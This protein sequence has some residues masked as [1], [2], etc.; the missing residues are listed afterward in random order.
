M[1][2]QEHIH[3]SSRSLPRTGAWSDERVL[4]D[5][6]CKR[7]GILYFAGE[8]ARIIG[9]EAL[10][11]SNARV[12]IWLRR[13]FSIGSLI[14]RS[15]LHTARPSRPEQKLLVKLYQGEPEIFRHPAVAVLLGLGDPLLVGG[16]RL[17]FA[18]EIGEY[19]AEA[20]I[21]VTF[22]VAVDS[23]IAPQNSR[24]IFATS[25]LL[26][27]VRQGQQ[28][29]RVVGVVGQHPLEIIY[30]VVHKNPPV[31]RC[32]CQYI[33]TSA[34]QHFST[35]ACWGAACVRFALCGGYGCASF[36]TE[37]GREFRGIT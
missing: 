3:A 10:R 2:H 4:P 33:S 28:P 6:L 23:D 32:M 13:R 1:T 24:L 27:L 26:V 14:S 17:V 5:V 31:D 36:A 34:G 19:A 7:R 30:P 16:P 15:T 25:G 29:R 35:S 8:P 21:S 12:P 11:D 22:V 18:P 9:P 37:P 20:C